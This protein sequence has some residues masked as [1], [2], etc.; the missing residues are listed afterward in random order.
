M[1]RSLFTGVSGLKQEQTRMDVLSNNI[2]NV[3][4]TGFKRG[5]ALFQDLFSQTIRHAQQSFG[6]YG[7]LNPMQV[8]LG[9]RL[10]TIDTLMEQGALESTG[11]KTDLAI[12]GAGFF[13]VKDQNGQPFYTRDGNLNINP[14]YDVVATNT[15]FQLQ[16]WLSTQDPGTG[17]LVLDNTGVTP[18]NLNI[19]K[20]L[21]KFA[22]QTNN[23][24]YASNLD[25]SSAERDIK[26]GVNTLTFDDSTGK[27]QNL[28]FKFSKR[29]STHWSWNAFSPTLAKYV[30]GGEIVTDNDGKVI[31]S[32]PSTTF[33]NF[34]TDSQGTYFIYDPDGD[35]IN[36]SVGGLLPQSSPTP[37]G[38]IQG[39][40]LLDAATS[41]Q[42]RDEKVKVVF[43]GGDP[44]QATSFRVLGGDN[45]FI[46]AGSLD[47]TTARAQGVALVPGARWD[48][49]LTQW[50]PTSNVSFN[51]TYTQDMNS[52]PAV[53]QESRVAAVNFVAPPAAPGYY[54][55]D[56]IKSTID[57][58]LRNA[59]ISGATTYDPLTKQ[60]SISTDYKGSNRHLQITDT[61]VLPSQFADL[62]L[63][64]VLQNGTGGSSPEV[65]SGLAVDS[66]N[67]GIPQPWP[68]NPTPIPAA[69]VT[70]SVSDGINTALVKFDQ[71]VLG[72]NKYYSQGEILSKIQDALIA[73]NVSGRVE[74]IDRNGDGFGDRLKLSGTRSGPQEKLTI[75]GTNINLLGFTAGNSYVGTALSGTFVCGGLNMTLTDNG[76]RHPWPGD[77][78]EI[79]TYAAKGQA[80][81]AKVYAPNTSTSKVVFQTTNP[82]TNVKYQISGDVNAGAK[83]STS[84][85][86]YDSLG[87]GH[88]LVT[89]W[90]HTNTGLKEWQFKVSYDKSDPE[91]QK[92]L[93]DPANNV[94]DPSNPTYDELERANNRLLGET[95]RKGIIR[96]LNNG[97]ID[98]PNSTINTIEFTPTGSN[99]LTLALNMDL[100]TEFDA[101]FTTAAR[102][103]D[104]YE[105]GLLESIYFEQDGTIR[106]VYSNGQKQPIG[107]VALAT[108][109]N[110]AGLEKKGKNL[111]DVSPNS[112]QA[113]VGKP[114]VGE[115]GT[116]APGSLEMSNVDI[117]EEFT[118]MIITQRAFQANS[119]IITTADEILQEVVN[120]KR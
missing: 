79:S 108:F 88:Q 110:P 33:T 4:T 13:I 102:E 16:G 104:G 86:V 89:E 44:Y 1:M 38:D 24:S 58:A 78:Y 41:S 40:T 11:K 56:N 87:S 68:T 92:Y 51:I 57:T 12:E 47:G 10:A 82:S 101:G 93:K 80:T 31:T 73:S 81:N 106:G 71:Q 61:S 103:Q 83:H 46:G 59:G 36:A 64:T 120:L 42:L 55:I 23:V 52:T 27:S 9:V 34:L 8:G 14:S 26:F 111:Y 60:I 98:R 3:N 90:E 21:K 7:G 66:Y 28:Q 37:H 76:S 32:T 105:M 94:I 70:L 117:A 67:G 91:I 25:S 96:F 53:P 6:N 17:N 77:T 49:N 43:D 62:G 116:L 45:R 119:R 113:V 95:A 15:G 84:I 112:G 69:G 50:T 2:A 54:T 97:K 63:P 65:F 118:N 20:Y 5:R 99:K 18:Y 39:L 75:G 22:H 100:I 35:P 30:A 74:L 85:S 115:R 29:D 107:L 114:M 19:M 72:V 48:A 109:N